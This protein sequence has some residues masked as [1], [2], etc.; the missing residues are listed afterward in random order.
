MGSPAAGTPEGQ[1]PAGRDCGEDLARVT[2][3]SV[4][5]MFGFEDPALD[6]GPV[7]GGNLRKE[8]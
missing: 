2:C 4:H 3:T 1:D 7:D 5:F 6:L 8:L